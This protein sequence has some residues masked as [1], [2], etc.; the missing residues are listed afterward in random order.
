MYVHQV[1]SHVMYTYAHPLY[2]V[3]DMPVKNSSY[4]EKY[5]NTCDVLWKSSDSNNKPHLK[6]PRNIQHD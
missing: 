5:N 3:A 1:N 2:S 6:I 4:N